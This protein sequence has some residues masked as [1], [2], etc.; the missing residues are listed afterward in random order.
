MAHVYFLILTLSVALYQTELH[1]RFTTNVH[2]SQKQ[3]HFYYR[4]LDMMNL[5]DNGCIT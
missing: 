5:G 3:C 2:I 4:Y 1:V